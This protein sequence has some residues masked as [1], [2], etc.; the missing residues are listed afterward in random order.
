ML[1]NFSRYTR[2]Q[3]AAEHIV[4][5][6]NWPLSRSSGGGGSPGATTYQQQDL[7]GPFCQLYQ[8]N[9]DSPHLTELL[10]EE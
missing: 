4:L 1:R 9:N 10:S 6:D 3:E 7:G 5:F 8:K 2:K